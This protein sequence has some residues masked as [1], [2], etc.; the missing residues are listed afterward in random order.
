MVLNTPHTRHLCTVR[1]GIGGAWQLF[2]FNR[3][4][5]AGAVQA[6]GGLALSGAIFTTDRLNAGCLMPTLLSIQNPGPE[7]LKEVIQQF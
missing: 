5:V 1:G 2:F 7:K 6:Q 4:G 3:P